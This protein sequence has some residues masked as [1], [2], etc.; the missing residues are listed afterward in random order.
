[1]MA[2]GPVGDDP[3]QL[4][5]AG[6]DAGSLNPLHHFGAPEAQLPVSW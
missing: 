6:A 2:D 3:T 4:V 1:L 5:F